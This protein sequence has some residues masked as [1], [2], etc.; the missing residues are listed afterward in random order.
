M[1]LYYEKFVRLSY[2]APLMIEEQKLSRFILR[3]GDDLAD[4]VETLQPATLS[5][6]LVQANAKLSRKTKSRTSAVKQTIKNY[7]GLENRNV[8]PHL[9]ATTQNQRFFNQPT[10]VQVNALPINQ[11][12]RMI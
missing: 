10:R 9:N 3:M 1:D 6:A 8:R 5:H 4:E 2:Y 7:Y 12:G 11:S